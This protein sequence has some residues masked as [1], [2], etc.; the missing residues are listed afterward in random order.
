MEEPCSILWFAWLGAAASELLAQ[1]RLLARTRPVS[2][3]RERDAPFPDFEPPVACLGARRPFRP[4][5]QAAVCVACLAVARNRLGILVARS[6]AMP[7]MCANTSSARPNTAV[8]LPTARAPSA[9]FLEPAVHRTLALA[10]CAGHLQRRARRAFFRGRD[11][12]ALQDLHPAVASGAALGG[13]PL[14]HLAI[15][16][17]W[18]LH[19]HL[20]NLLADLLHAAK[21][22]DNAM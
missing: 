9:P 14:G 21:L 8:A 12:D 20:E 6:A 4:C 11:H 5:G 22:C 3:W 16:N 18:P 2:A 13:R 10:T 17:K 15:L 1:V 19:I 7:R